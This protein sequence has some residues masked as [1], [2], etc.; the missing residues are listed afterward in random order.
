MSQSNETVRKTLVVAV[1]LSIV[2]SVIVSGA[3][4]TLR[5]MQDEN[6]ALSQRSNMM[7]AAGLLPMDASNDKV[8]EAFEKFDVLLV[9]MGTGEVVDPE[10]VNSESATA[11]DQRSA[12]RDPELSRG[13]DKDPAGINR[14]VK[15]GKIFVLREEG[16]LKR[17]VLPIHGYGLW[18]TM[19]GY[20]ALEGDS[21]SV[22]GVRFYEHAETPGLGGEIENPDWVAKWKGKKIYDEGA[23]PEPNFSLVKGGVGPET[24]NREHKVDALS[25]ATLTSRGVESTVNF[26]MGERAYGPFLKKLKKRES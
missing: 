22:A 7:A 13:L 23:R 10:T 2:F 18:S 17:I 20:L 25:G 24:A 16:Q 26:W 12:T 19:Y 3:A 15:Y 11:Y 14:L 8:S 9:E 21:N 4:V 6:K 1:A 5:P